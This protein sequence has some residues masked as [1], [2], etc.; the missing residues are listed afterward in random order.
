MQDFFNMNQDKENPGVFARFYV[1]PYELKKKSKEAGRPIYEDREYVEIRVQGDS[2]MVIDREVRE[3]DRKRWARQ[4][5]AFA[6]GKDQPLDGT[7]IEQWPIISES[8]RKEL[9]GAGIRT[10]EA[11]AELREDIIKKLGMDTRELVKMAKA[12]LE[13]AEGMEPISR[14]VSEAEMLKR[15]VESLKAE[16]AELK[17]QIAEAS[18]AA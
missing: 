17:A 16:N 6:E 11:L 10:V 2:K 7:A 5:D 13:K 9:I 3:E 12:Y 1:K 8:K 14:L 15:E 4:Y 18:N